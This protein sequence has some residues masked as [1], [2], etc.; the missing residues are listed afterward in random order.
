[1]NLLLD[2][3]TLIWFSG[4]DTK[5]LSKEAKFQIENK[6]NSKF[7]SIV[8]FWEIAIKT[9]IGRLKLN[10]DL[11]ELKEYIGKYNFN[12]LSISIEH[13]LEVQRLKFI[14]RDPFDRILIAQALH[15]NFEIITR[16]KN[17]KLYD[18]KTIW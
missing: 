18:I 5:N 11:A 2:T 4:G 10:K 13:T 12:L 8:S 3:H 1:M 6:D 7:V 15:E 9:G 16:D 14:H 17:I